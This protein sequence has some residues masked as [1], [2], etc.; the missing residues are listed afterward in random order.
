MYLKSQNVNLKSVSIAGVFQNIFTSNDV[1]VADKLISEILYDTNEQPVFSVYK[2]YIIEAAKD[3]I[4]ALNNKGEEQWSIPV[5]LNSPIV[6]TNGTDLLVSDIGGRDIYVINSGKVIW[7]KKL[8]SNIINIDIS[9]SGYISVVH[10][11]KGYK[12]AVAVFGPQG[13]E[14]FTRYILKSFTITATV[15]PSEK[16]FLINGVD[17][18]GVRSGAS[19]ELFDM[20]GKPTVDEILIDNM[21]F[22][23]VWY[24]NN[25]SILAASDSTLICLDS[26]GKKKWEKEF[27]DNKVYSS[28]E[29]SGKYAVIAVS[30]GG[31]G[32]GQDSA[33]IIIYD[34]AG[35]E[36]A[37]YVID[38]E[39]RSI[40]TYSDIIAVNL[41]REV[42]FI[43][44]RGKLIGKYASKTDITGV[45]FFNKQMAAIVNRGSVAVIKI[46]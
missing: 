39:V 3:S 20:T 26:E 18:S 6:K 7:N 24:M 43:N 8:D 12:G 41:G 31:N 33:R 13:N 32:T 19:L 14:M 45:Y 35:N 25:E 46:K 28:N 44:A 27:T 15:S 17:T 9:K 4:K 29:L 5:V 10:D 37:T 16:Q 42:H 23:S 38:N 40:E 30:G 21:I 36:Y 22:S 1:K 11:A 2:D 34:M